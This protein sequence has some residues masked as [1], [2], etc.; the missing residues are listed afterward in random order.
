MVKP[1]VPM[2]PE[3]T[4]PST[5]PPSRPH[6]P[7]VDMVLA[8]PAVDAL[9]DQHG[10]PLVLA[11]VREEL[12][13]VRQVAKHITD[14][15]LQQGITTRLRAITQ[16]SLRRVFNLTG[17]VLHT[18]LGRAPLPPE[19]LRA[20]NDVA[21][22]ASNLE[23]DLATGGRGDRDEHIE[24]WLQ[25]LTGA[26][27]A[28]VVNNNA[29][30]LMLVLATLAK[31][32]EVIVSRGE[33]VEIGGAFRLPDIM[34]AA[35]CRLRE[36]GTTNR[37]RLADVIEAMNAKTALVLKVH[38]SNYRIEGFTE[39]PDERAL[40]ALCRERGVPFVIDLGSGSLHDLARYG[41]PHEPTPTEALGA[42]ADL[43]TFSG[44]KLLGGPQAGIVVGRADLIARLKKNPFKRAL[45]C[46]KLT[47]AALAAVLPL[48]GDPDRLAQRLPTLRW[49]T[50][51]VGDI[52]AQAQRLLPCL[53]EW[54]GSMGQV[55]T[56]TTQSQIGSGALPVNRLTSVALRLTPATAKR[57]SGRALDNL[58]ARLRA[59]PKPV[60]GRLFDG[61]VLLDLRCLD[62]P[63][64]EADFI[65]QLC[66]TPAP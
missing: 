5:P 13:H 30:A 45:R 57:Q 63:Q 28:T 64:D 66:A 11:A 39:S 54:L 37:T 55:E 6:L 4:R 1:T 2:L 18:N 42:G 46:D 59:L 44:D 43:V 36:V 31:R 60:I 52:A 27:A 17:T 22:G 20:I 58:A 61:A 51:P 3:P 34:A 7:A 10:R 48:H 12:A 16:P 25:R 53:A 9:V 62:G 33:L 35:G 21:S 47:L 38:T 40:A 24:P 50:R 29:A 41:L 23:F 56:L 26:A 65:A 32:R 14:Q 15:A 49:L 19:A 8:W